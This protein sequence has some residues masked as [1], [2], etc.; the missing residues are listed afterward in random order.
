[1]N[2]SRVIT[3]VKGLDEILNGGLVKER[4]YLVRGGPGTGKTT[5][6]LHFLK[7]GIEENEKSLLITLTESKQ[8]IKKDAKKRKLDL[9]KV[10]FIDLSPGSELIKNNEEYNVFPTNQV[11]EK[12]L[13]DSIIDKIKEIKPDRIFF[14]GII[15]LKYLTNDNF[16]FRKKLLSFIQFS[17]DQESTLLLSSESNRNIADDDLQFL[18]DGVINL[19]FNSRR[20]TISISKFRGSDFIKGEHTYKLNKQ[21]LIIFPKL[22]PPTIKSDIEFNFCSSGLKQIDNLLHGGIEKGTVS[23]ITGPSGV[24]KTTLGSQFIKNAIKND[25]KAILYTFEESK[26][27]LIKRANSINI[28]LEEGEENGN[29]II[30]DIDPSKCI[31]DEFAQKV[32]EQVED[33]EVEMIMIDSITSY[34]LA[35]QYSTSNNEIIKSLHTL[36]H[37]LKKRGITLILTNEQKKLT[38]S[39]KITD[40][41]ISHLADNIVFLRYIER[42]GSLIKV[43]GVLKKRLSGFEN[44]LREFKITSNGLKVGE[45]LND[46]RNILNGTPELLDNTHRGAN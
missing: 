10:E 28:S 24:G 20:R 39:F 41:N 5:L 8:K 44:T 33:N 14:D 36:A 11:E 45:P 42:Q 35:Y 13:I 26:E 38:G 4:A 46:L 25:K 32:R 6:G 2:D 21:G 3:G 15:Q 31:P 19:N 27:F 7:K 23:V 16:K 30:K 40:N 37:Y 12:P 43:I 18:V 34:R 1:M 22:Q 9:K 29:L 17:L